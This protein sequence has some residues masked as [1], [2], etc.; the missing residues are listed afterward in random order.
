VPP[1]Y[2]DSVYA[3]VKGTRKN[4]FD[5]SDA[6][7]TRKPDCKEGDKVVACGSK[8]GKTAFLVYFG[9]QVVEEV[10]DAQRPGCPP[11]YFNIEIPNG[12]RFR[13]E[14][15]NKSGTNLLNGKTE[16]PFLR[17]RYDQRTG[18]GPSNP[19][20]QLNEITPWIDGGLIYGT[21]KAWADVLRTDIN[22][23]LANRG[24]LASDSE[25]LFPVRNKI[26]LPM[27]NPPPPAFHEEFSA[28]HQTSPVE[29]FFGEY[30]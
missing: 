15:H 6:L 25:G 29:R 13:G 26:R 16:M 21:S 24:L 9:Q 4:P 18:H 3:P 8:T 12:H 23:K 10:L 28:R 1:V 5:I 22:G 11:E 19:R 14:I 20:Q 27:A 2:E 7:M 17:S 30:L